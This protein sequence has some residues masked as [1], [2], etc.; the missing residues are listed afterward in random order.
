[1]MPRVMVDLEA[2]RVRH[3]GLGQ[4]SFSLGNALLDE[5]PSDLDFCFFVRKKQRHYFASS[6]VD[7][8]VA[9]PWRR[10]FYCQ[11]LRPILKRLSSEPRCDVWHMSNQNARFWPLDPRT[12]MLLTVHDLN[13]LREREP[14]RIPHELRKVQAKIDRAAHIV[15]D[16]Q[17][18][19]DEIREHLQ[20]RDK[21]VSVIHLGADLH[22]T[23]TPTR[24]A[25]VDE[26]PF[27]F[28]IG[29]ITAKKN[30]LVLI[31]LIE[32]LPGQQLV[33]A[34][35][36]QSDYAKAIENTVREK[37]LQDRVALPGKISG[38]ERLWLYQNCEAFWFPSTTEGFGLPVIEAMS[39]G[40][41]VFLSH[42]TCLPEVG[43]ELGNYWHA[44]DADHMLAVYHQG[45]Q[46]AQA[47]ADH[48]ER[49]RRHA[50]QFTWQ[51]TAAQ[52]I[53]LYRQVAEQRH[54][55]RRAAA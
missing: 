41:P 52:Y 53:E 46:R 49:S 16:T 54:A 38:G 5:R 20:L 31:D 32:R 4:F 10:E 23:D 42:A 37:G 45:M 28:T 29:E 11:A 30:F 50:A 44:Y 47:T 39:A 48:A 27:V 43:G 7:Q 17:F 1:M 19:A 51:R 26:R 24:P 25:F 8:A 55:Q 33:I 18:V 15:T 35:C 13:F 34:G 22:S 40:K 2:L 14:G 21:P 36:K 9:T 3:C 6:G 12:P